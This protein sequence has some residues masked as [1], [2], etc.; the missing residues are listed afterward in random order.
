M[1]PLPKHYSV[2]ANLSGELLGEEMSLAALLC[3]AF[4]LG[5]T[6]AAVAAGTNPCGEHDRDLFVHGNFPFQGT[7][8]LGNPFKNALPFEEFESRGR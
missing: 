5:C 2:I 3:F 1:Q 7:P 4:P 8:F 6:V